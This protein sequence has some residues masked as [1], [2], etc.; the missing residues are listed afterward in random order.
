MPGSAFD[1][2]DISPAFWARPDVRRA[3]ADRDIGGLFRLLNHHAGLTQMRIGTAVEM[4]QGRVSDIVRGKY[5]VQTVPV[6]TRIADGLDMPSQARILLGLAPRP[7]HVPSTA[8]RRAQTGGELAGRLSDDGPRYLPTTGQAV[9]AITRLWR[10][11]AEHAEALL[12]APLDPAAWNDAALSWLVGQPEPAPPAPPRQGHAVGLA[13]VARVRQT[14]KLFAQLDNQY[15]G[16]HAR[17]ALI[18]YL[19]DDAAGLLQRRYTDAV[20]RELLGAVAEASLLAAWASYDEGLHGLAQRYFIQALRLAQ[21]AADRRLGCSVL[22]AM[23][24]QATFLG[25]LPEAVNLS[26][27]AETGVAPV[28]TPTLTAQFQVMQA[29]ALARSGDT[30]ACHLA[31]AATERSFGQADP[32]QDPEFISYFNE[33]ELAAE[34]AHC[35]RDPG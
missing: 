11:D 1:P 15:G 25:H 24:H 19:R 27:A 28:A 2:P 26:R 35:L 32:G 21:S 8:P 23:S 5:Q 20:G 10:A 30:R 34:F 31:L 3:L 16:A 22:S 13:D 14:V 33:S 18:S 6:F 12:S 17:R 7:A 29:R 9:T 4:A